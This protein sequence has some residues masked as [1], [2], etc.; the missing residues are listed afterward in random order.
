MIEFCKTVA[1]LGNALFQTL[2]RAFY[3]ITIVNTQWILLISNTRR[4]SQEK[5]A[6]T[7]SIIIRLV[8]FLH[9]ETSKP[10]S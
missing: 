3:V 7:E 8:K 6:G 5:T 10:N 1:Y 2:R 4:N 9:I